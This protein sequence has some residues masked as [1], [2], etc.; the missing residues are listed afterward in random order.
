MFNPEISI[1]VPVYNQEKLLQQCIDSI[2]A[3]NF[4]NFELILIDDGSTD[5]SPQ[6]CDGYA[7]E[8]GNVRVIHQKN[9]GV[10]AARN[11]GLDAAKGTYLMFCDSDDWVDPDWCEQLYTQI[12][13][14]DVVMAVCGHMLEC[15]E[16]ESVVKQALPHSENVELRDW[17]GFYPKMCLVWDKI[18]IRELVEAHNIRFP[19]QIAFAEDTRF[20]MQYLRACS[21]QQYFRMLLCTPYHYR[22][23]KESLS[24]KYIHGFWEMEKDLMQ[25]VLSTARQLNT[26]LDRCREE[27]QHQMYYVVFTA[28]RNLFH[29]QNTDGLWK[30]YRK[31]REILH[32]E[33]CEQA[34]LAKESGDFPGWYRWLF[35]HRAAPLLFLYYLWKV[36]PGESAAPRS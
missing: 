31:L 9:A 21:G 20:V 2:L 32:S 16:G 36:A 34:L 33:M 5:A 6:I 23:M 27:M 3:Q 10:S 17:L 28:I 18:L 22:V 24:R 26:D 11:A 29:P 13:Q 19:A 30:K 8:C 35:R 14:Q 4:Q 1:I 12:T 25:E 7:R 15:G